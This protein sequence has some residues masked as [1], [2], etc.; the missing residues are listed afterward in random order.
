MLLLGYRSAP[1]RPFIREALRVSGV[2]N[3][4]FPCYN[5]YT[6]YTNVSLCR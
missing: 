4:E 5:E 1:R 3:D 6:C 2:R